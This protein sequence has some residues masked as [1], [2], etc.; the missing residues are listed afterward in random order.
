MYLMVIVGWLCVLYGF[1]IPFLYFSNGRGYLGFF[2][3]C[4]LYEIQ[5]NVNEK[6]IKKAA[7][8][9][10]VIIIML[11]SVYILYGT[12]KFWGNVNLS[13]EI[14]I[15][16]LLI[17]VVNNINTIKVILGNKFINKVA[18]LSTSIYFS[19]V[20]VL[21]TIKLLVLKYDFRLKYSAA[22]TFLLVMVLVV[23]FASA[24][25]FLVEEKLTNYF[26]SKFITK[27]I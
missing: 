11:I 19:H 27:K 13:C 12:E 1:N 2:I 21:N 14:L 23:L 5:L 18:T 15:F 20:I 3:G 16:P 8:I 9:G 10:L 24:Y 6:M 4:L 7:I 17:L 22:D 25:K 26:K